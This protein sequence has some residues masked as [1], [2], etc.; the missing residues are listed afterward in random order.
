MLLKIILLVFPAE[1]FESFSCLLSWPNSTVN[2]VLIKK[3][4]SLIWEFALNR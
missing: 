4:S 3:E 2:S 1:L